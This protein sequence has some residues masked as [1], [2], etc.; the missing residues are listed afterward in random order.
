MRWRDPE[1]PFERKAKDIRIGETAPYGDLFRRQVSLFEHPSGSFY[2]GTLYPRLGRHPN[3]GSK[4]PGKMARAHAHPFGEPLDTVLQRRVRRDPTLDFLKRGPPD[5][6]G[7]AFPA[8][9]ELP[10]RSLE[11][12]DELA[13]DTHRNI[14]SKILLDEGKS[15][16]EPSGH[17]GRCTNLAITNMD[18][19]FINSHLGI[20]RGERL[21]DRPMRRHTQTIEEAGRRQRESTA[22]DRTKSSRPRCG[23]PEP[24]GHM[25]LEW[26]FR[27]IRPAGD[28]QGID[29]LVPVTPDDMIRDKAHT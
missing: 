14:P 3:L 8:E 6:H 16:I 2:P 23:F 12:H 5:W 15:E 26:P 9:L 20:G 25:W 13:C 19:V 17:A 1:A 7:F 22:A 18:G 10:A 24:F 28:K 27:G 4:Q 21:S 11:E 29:R